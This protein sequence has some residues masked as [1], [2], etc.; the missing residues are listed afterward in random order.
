MDLELRTRHLRAVVSTRG[1][2]LLS[3]E[4][5]NGPV[6]LMR[7]FDPDA[8]SF[9][10]TRA[11]AFPLVP[12]G[13]RVRDNGFRFAGRDIRFEPNTPGGG[14]YLHGDAWLGDWRVVERSSRGARLV[15]EH[16]T[17]PVS[18]Y[19]YSA[20]QSFHLDESG[21]RVSFSVT[22][23]GQRPLPFGLGHHPYFPWRDGTEIRLGGH[24]ALWTESSDHLPGR[25]MAFPEDLL[26][27]DYAGPPRRRVNNVIDAWDGRAWVRW[28]NEGVELSIEASEAF[29]WLMLFINT[30]ERDPGYRFEYFCLEPMTHLPG[31]H[32]KTSNAGFVVLEPG[33]ML[34]GHVKYRIA[35][36]GLPDP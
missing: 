14:A 34:T 11:A 13:N 20:E 7:P 2:C 29:R 3:F 35:V 10:P 12:F 17:D 6:A 30:P 28:P 27:D 22:N 21:L 24:G 26:F 23:G 8:G 25:A 31:G 16:E 1:G 33:G 36:N 15:F 32:D 19:A 18:P 5:V 9:H 4:C